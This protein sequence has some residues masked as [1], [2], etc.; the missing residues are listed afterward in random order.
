MNGA[1][2]GTALTAKL[3]LLTSPALLREKREYVGMLGT[4]ARLNKLGRLTE[5][6]ASPTIMGL[7]W[8][9]G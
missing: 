6:Q 3:R 5:E 8:D 9:L 1:G 4:H 2:I 7:T